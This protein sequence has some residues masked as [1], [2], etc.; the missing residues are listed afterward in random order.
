MNRYELLEERHESRF[1]VYSPKLSHVS[2][3]DENVHSLRLT[4]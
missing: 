4:E 2:E 3:F 1:S